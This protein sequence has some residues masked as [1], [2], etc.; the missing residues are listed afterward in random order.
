MDVMDTLIIVPQYKELKFLVGSFAAAGYPTRSLTLGRLACHVREDLGLLFAVG[1]HGKTQLAVQT[2]H[3][4]DQTPGLQ[5]VICA[6][7]A[8]SLREELMLGDIVVGTATIEHD[9]KL[10]FVR[11]PP[12]CHEADPKLLREFHSIAGQVS[13]NFRLRFG[14]I[15]S[16][17]EDI[18][19]RTRALEL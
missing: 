17:D 8:G 4:I 2:Q 11:R 19:D 5:A 16:G 15:A 3:L 12:P 18:V 1:G 9:Y 14:A 7:A 10:R 6:G 13:V